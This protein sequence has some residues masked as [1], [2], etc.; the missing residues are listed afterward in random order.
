MTAFK[1]PVVLDI[2]YLLKNNNNYNSIIYD[3]YF[4]LLTDIDIT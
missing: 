1:N 3:Q 2:I 4:Y